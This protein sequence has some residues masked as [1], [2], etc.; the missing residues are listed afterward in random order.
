MNVVVKFFRGAGDWDLSLTAEDFKEVSLRHPIYVENTTVHTLWDTTEWF[1]P[2]QSYFRHRKFMESLKDEARRDRNIQDGVVSTVS[3][4]GSDVLSYLFKPGVADR[5]SEM[6]LEMARIEAVALVLDPTRNVLV[7]GHSL[8]SVGAYLFLRYLMNQFSAAGW[9]T[10][11]LKSRV[12]L[13]LLAPAMG[14]PTVRN[15]VA[16]YLPKTKAVEIT[17]EAA[18]VLGGSKDVLRDI[19][20]YGLM[21]APEWVPS[22]CSE[23]IWA[24]TRE[25]LTHDLKPLI[26][27]LH[28][29]M[30]YS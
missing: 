10:H 30:R 22:L 13:A 3:K 21:D 28:Q 19:P 9:E 11:K 23:H 24:G 2:I 18:V 16:R 26:N 27:I 4:V 6:I 29:F 14:F 12:K 20:T 1:G 7:C 5:Y 25:G 15:K 8:G 17:I